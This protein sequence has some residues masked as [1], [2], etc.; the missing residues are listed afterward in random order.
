MLLPM[1]WGGS[2]VWPPP[3]L[4]CQEP[5]GRA[6]GVTHNGIPPTICWGPI[7]HHL[8]SNRNGSFEIFKIASLANSGCLS[9]R[10]RKG[11]CQWPLGV[12]CLCIHRGHCGYVC[13]CWRVCGREVGGLPMYDCVH[14]SFSILRGQRLN[15]SL[16]F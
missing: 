12:D 6:M 16:L 7:S 15:I 8:L 3:L 1:F 13:V 5:G 4:S 10:A 11:R 14:V 2:R 9:Y